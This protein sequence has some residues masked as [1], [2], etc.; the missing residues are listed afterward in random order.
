MLARL[1]MLM[2]FFKDSDRKNSIRIVLE[3]LHFAIIKKSTPIDY[4][5][6]FLYRK[7][8]NNYLD[9]LSLKQYYSIIESEKMVFPEVSQ[10]LKNKLSFKLM[11]EKQGLSMTNMFGYNLRNQFIINEKTVGIVN[12]EDLYN[13]LQDLFTKNKIDKIFIKPMTGVGGSGCMLLN[14]NDLQTFVKTRFF[15]IM[16]HSYLFENYIEQH[17]A[18]NGINASAIN[19][20]RIVHYIN[21]KQTVHILSTLMR[22][23]VGDSITD[24]TSCGG[25]SIAVNSLTG[26]LEGSG[27]QDLAKGGAVYL[28]H[29]DTYHQL[30]GFTIP[31]FKEACDLV[32]S[33]ACIFPNRIVGWDI[34]IT[35][36][37]PLIIEANHNPSLYLSDIAYGGLMKHPLIKEILKEIN[38]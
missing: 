18:I 4:F 31:Y 25:F 34:A 7:S 19:T 9:Y 17:P 3:C 30:E 11:A 15:D 26:K 16:E 22:F 28:K 20:L 5:R 1:K 38:S 37:G 21:K 29:P 13:V 8:A 6:N 27:R 36:S 14:K 32:L 33:A 12:E 35:G 24:N 10:I 23:G 2:V